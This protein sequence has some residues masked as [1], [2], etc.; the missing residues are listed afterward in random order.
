MSS[1][2]MAYL[3]MTVVGFVVFSIAL[4]WISASEH[5]RVH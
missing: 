5:R 1:G 3:A 4:A 2:E